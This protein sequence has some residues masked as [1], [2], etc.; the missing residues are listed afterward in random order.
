MVRSTQSEWGFGGWGGGR[1]GRVDFGKSE[2]NK[3]ETVTGT[4]YKDIMHSWH[5]KQT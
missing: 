1:S 4:G 2:W 3:V 5:I